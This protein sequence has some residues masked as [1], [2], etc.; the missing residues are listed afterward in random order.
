[1]VEHRSSFDEVPNANDPASV[2]PATVGPP[3]A[4]PGDPHGVEWLADGASSAT[5]TRVRPSAWSGWPA[6]W[7]T[8]AWNGR[9]EALTDTA[10]TCLDKNASILASMPPYLV[11][12]SPSL[13][14][15]WL[16]NPDPDQYTSWDEFTKQLFWD[17]QMGEAFVLVTAR[18]ANGYPAR[19]HVV[20]PW[21]V[22]VEFGRDGLRRYAIG[23]VDVSDDMLHVRY[24]STV[25]DARGHGPL[26]AG[27]SR[28]VAASALA[29]YASNLAASGGI[30]NAVL[31]HPASLTAAQATALQ[32]AWVDARM[33]SLGLPA[34]LSGGLDFR[35]L[36][37]NPRDMALVDLAQFNE[38]RIAVLLGVPP[39]LVGLPSGGDSMTYTNVNML[40]EYYWRSGLRPMASAV[41]AA[42]SGWLLPRGTTVELNRDEFVRPGP[43]ELAQTFQ[44]LISA[45]IMQPEQAAEVLRL[46][47]TAPVAAVSE[48]VLQ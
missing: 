3:A 38:S 39:V 30:P 16:N 17:Y 32:T 33:S 14:A 47:M 22:N 8:P 36:S 48:G 12:A 7:E 43:L 37:L 35:T 40:F 24:Q 29:R 23:E 11:G 21:L 1:M 46:N 26:E 19:F 2:P 13:P 9:V 27:W 31:T 45:G 5:V 41:M 28:V 42:L 44:I 6:D 15:D 34:V 18:Y 10:W 20:A 4:V 25:G